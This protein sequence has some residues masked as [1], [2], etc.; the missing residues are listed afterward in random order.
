MSVGKFIV[1][2]GCDGVGKSTLAKYLKTVMEHQAIECVVHSEPGGT[3]NANLI[4]NEILTNLDESDYSSQGELF[5]FLAARAYAVK[6]I[7]QYMKNG[8]T[9]IC[10]RWLCS[11][12]AYQG[13]D[14]SEDGTIYYLHNVVVG[15]LTPD[16]SIHLTLPKEKAREAILNRG[17]SNSFD[18]RNISTQ[19]FEK[20]FEFIQTLHRASK[21]QHTLVTIERGDNP[22]T[23]AVDIFDKYLKG[24]YGI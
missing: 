10:D 22:H 12:L 1:I 16:I 24:L 20:A 4:R 7:K 9:V 6:K 13:H 5:L 3:P 11:T 8:I 14:P 18:N 2:D 21:Q 23:Q 15:G 19:R 17:D